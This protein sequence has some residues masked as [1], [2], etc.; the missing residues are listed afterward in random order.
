[1]TRALTDEQWLADLREWHTAREAAV[2][3]PYGIAANTG[4][5]WLSDVPEVIDGLAGEWIAVA[6][7]AVNEQLGLRLAAGQ[8]HLIDEKLVKVIAPRP[9][10]LAVRVFD[11]AAP[12][13][14]GVTGIDTF[15]PDPAWIIEGRFEPA[16]PDTTIAIEHFDGVTTDDGLAGT[17]H[18]DI[19][20]Q[21]LRLA[22]WAASDAGDLEFTFTDTANDVNTAG[23]RFLQ[24]A[25]PDAD[26]VVI[27]DFNRAFLPSCSLGTG[28]LC[29]IPPAQ[30]R[31]PF[32]VEAGEHSVIR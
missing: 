3:A 1:M 18:L 20:D 11:P 9:Q 28:Y 12:T 31:L 17:I 26:G 19:A 22:A 21:Q 32:A 6:G 5:T 24:V 16:D 7:D 10:T 13:R 8:E 25:A 2:L 15:T 23:F 29:P 27:L 30:N 14:V 4:T